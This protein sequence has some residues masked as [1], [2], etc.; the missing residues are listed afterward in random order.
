[1]KITKINVNVVQKEG[2]RLKAYA[3][4]MLE[5]LAIR[6]LRIIGKFQYSNQSSERQKDLQ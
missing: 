2:T 1:M 3:T 5:E 4:V 6:N